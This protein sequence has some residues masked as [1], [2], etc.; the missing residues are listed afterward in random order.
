MIVI[1][2]D[3]IRNQKDGQRVDEPAEK[4]LDAL[5]HDGEVIF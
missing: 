5:F 2:R 1:G 3:L 4:P